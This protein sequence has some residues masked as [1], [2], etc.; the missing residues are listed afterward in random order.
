[1]VSFIPLVMSCLMIWFLIRELKNAAV[2]KRNSTGGISS[3]NRVSYIILGLLLGE[4]GAHNFYAG[5]PVNGVAK[6]VLGMIFML[7]FLVDKPDANIVG[8]FGLVVVGVW[9][10][11]EAAIRTY[12]FDGKLMK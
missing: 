10:I 8:A 4:F 12:D 3:R 9:A 2:N 1:M 5:F 7:A 11:F 6:F